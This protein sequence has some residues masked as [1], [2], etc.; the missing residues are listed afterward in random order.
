MGASSLI[1]RPLVLSTSESWR[2]NCAVARLTQKQLT[3]AGYVMGGMVPADA[4]RIAY[5]TT[6]DANDCGR[7]ARRLLANPRIAPLIESAQQRIV[8]A[9]ALDAHNVMRLWSQ[10]ATVDHNEIAEVR[11]VACRF[12]WS[13]VPGEPQETPGEQKR[14]RKEFDRQVKLILASAREG[15]AFAVPEF[16]E[17]GGVGYDARRAPN[18]ACAECFGDGDMRTI[19]KDS[20]RM[21]AA[22]RAAFMG[23]DVKSGAVVVKSVDRLKATELV[24][25]GL[26]LLKDGSQPPPGAGQDAR[27][28]TPSDPIEAAQVYRRFI[29]GE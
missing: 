4:Y 24:A 8:D 14:R 20:R 23:I 28:V 17:L 12:C 10:I 7:E 16:D 22:A 18:P 11:R 5:D 25:R 9:N 19:I 27:N 13:P 29:E 15:K 26:G 1:P 6:M 3:F 2:Y 21:S